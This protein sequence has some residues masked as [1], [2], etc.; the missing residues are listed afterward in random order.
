MNNSDYVKLM[1]ARDAARERYYESFDAQA[2]NEYEDLERQVQT[3]RCRRLAE[4]ER[5]I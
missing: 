5:I 1:R 2:L 4:Q 3:E